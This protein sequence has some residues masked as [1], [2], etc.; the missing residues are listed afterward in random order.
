MTGWALLA[1]GCAMLAG[2]TAPA[3]RSDLRRLA[4][5]SDRRR[6]SVPGGPGQLLRTVGPLVMPVVAVAT[7]SWA[8][9][10][11]S[12]VI[13][14]A[15]LRSSRA[16][17]AR[18]ARADERERATS[19]CTA[20]AAE[21]RAGRPAADALTAAA[22]VAGIHPRP[23]QRR[24]PR[25]PDIRRRGGPRVRG[26]AGPVDRASTQ[27]ESVVETLSRAA[28][29]EQA[30][31]SAAGVLAAAGGPGGPV[32]RRLAV[33]WQVGTTAGAGLAG[34]VDGVATGLRRRATVEREVTMALS[35]PRAT[36]RLVAGL[37][38]LGLLM[39]AGLGADPWHV[40]LRTGWGGGCLL[41]AVVLDTAG[42]AWTDRLVDRAEA[43]G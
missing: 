22:Q 21:L 35:G 8:A 11:A 30:G 14:V 27:P 12:A 3:G 20:L 6:G 32:L 16:S 1:V 26:P 29:T 41:A 15:V 19:A 31:G 43:P 42:V 36:A 40:L 34:A 17:R 39:A 2:A 37:P 24:D 10:L 25:G 38:A 13:T 23:V 7:R 33:C 18:S 5:I 4:G 28:A 9:V